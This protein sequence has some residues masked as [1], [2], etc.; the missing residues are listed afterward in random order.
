MAALAASPFWLDCHAFQA[1]CRSADVHV[2]IKGNVL[3]LLDNKQSAAVED[4]GTGGVGCASRPQWIKRF[5][6]VKANMLGFAPHSDAPFEGAYLLEDVEVVEYSAR[7]ALVE[8]V[9]PALPPVAGE[10]AQHVLCV[11]NKRDLVYGRPIR[12]LVLALTS[13]LLAQSWK[14]KVEEANFKAA[15]TELSRLRT[16][17]RR[18]RSLVRRDHEKNEICASLRQTELAE[19]ESLRTELLLEIQRLQQRTVR[20]QASGEITEK[21]AAEYID[22]KINEI[23]AL[24][25][26]L[27]EELRQKAMLKKTIADL[28]EHAS[29]QHHRI[30]ALEAE[31][32]QLACRHTEL[33]KDLE[34]ASDNPARLSLIM[35]RIRSNNQRLTV[36][37]KRLREE[38]RSLTRHFHEIEEKFE[39]KL[40]MV[41]TVAEAGDVFDFL[42]KW[43]LC[44][45]NKVK[46][47]EMGYKMTEEEAQE[48]RRKIQR[49]Q[50]EIRIAE[51]VARSSYISVR[52]ILLDEQLKS[53]TRS[54]EIPSMY[55][56]VKTS[57]D[58]FGWVFG[59]IEL[60]KPVDRVH[61]VEL[62]YWLHA[63]QGDPDVPLL[64]RTYPC[65]GLESG[66]RFSLVK[67]VDVMRPVESLIPLGRFMALQASYKM[68][69]IDHQELEDNYQRA[70]AELSEYRNLVR[71]LGD[72]PAGIQKPSALFR[73][74]RTGAPPRKGVSFFGSVAGPK[75]PAGT[76][77]STRSSLSKPTDGRISPRTNASTDLVPES[78]STFSDD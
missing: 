2:R 72:A 74:D 28:R 76:V 21:A 26:Q 73:G 38:N 12:R 11:S 67:G 61:G 19:M 25:S 47:Y 34:D 71:D 14:E 69:E 70:L 39:D 40:K 9:I 22:Q 10:A 62:P 41:R 64:E 6:V 7:E 51:A 20:L 42:R 56:F 49:L 54:A 55:S 5:C 1:L 31:Q 58:R 78:G 23:S 43:L 75:Q 3:L 60:V 52:S 17:S 46:F 32:R 44:S 8:G 48:Q 16:E 36:E 66:S 4:D 53:Y 27:A 57:L 68:L 18:E 35:S 15:Q 77:K 30:A 37:N 65:G 59:E 45:E 33:L 13:P 29:K 63:S 24:Q 50:N